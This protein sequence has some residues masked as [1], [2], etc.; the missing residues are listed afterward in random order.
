MLILHLFFVYLLFN[1]V[2]NKYINCSSRVEVV[3]T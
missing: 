2:R 3:E 1:F